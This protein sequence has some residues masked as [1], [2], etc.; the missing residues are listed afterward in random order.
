MIFTDGKH[1]IS[2]DNVNEL[3]EFA[4]MIGLKREWFQ[5]FKPAK[6]KGKRE[7]VSFRPH[8]DLFGGKL[9]RAIRNG[10]MVIDK[11]SLAL[12]AMANYN[13]PQDTVEMDFSDWYERE[14][15]K[16]PVNIKLMNEKWREIITQWHKD[17]PGESLAF[18]CDFDIPKG[19]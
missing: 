3:H 9:Q 2:D 14:R 5:R 8:Y 12:I 10:A 6:K 18:M 13:F 15:K 17:N 19:E 7:N 11:R 1:L 16:G 4:E